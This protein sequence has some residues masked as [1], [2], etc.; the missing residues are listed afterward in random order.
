MGALSE[1]LSDEVG[2]VDARSSAVGQE[3]QRLAL[4]AVGASAPQARRALRALL[5]GTSYDD[6]ADDAVLAL[7]ELVTN[8]VLHGREPLTVLLDRDGARLR[9]EVSDGSPLGPSFSM[10]DP[11]AVTGRGLLL[12]SSCADRWGVE[13]TADGKRVWF[14]V[15]AAPAG[16][17]GKDVDVDALLASWG[18]ELE[19]PADEVVRVVL[20]DLD[21]GLMARS[22]AHVDA[23]LR[24]LALMADAGSCPPAARRLAD[25]VQVAAAEVEALRA[26]VKRQL[27]LAVAGEQCQLDVT[28]TITRVDADTVRDFAAVVDEADRLTRTGELLLEPADRRLSEVRQRYLRRIVAQLAS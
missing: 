25:R 10:L 24:E 13:P 20:T 27:T 26:E 23:L 2:D 4:P 5:H 22:E 6:R 19:D 15:D 17:P 16:A 9:V 18:E 12:V 21:T 3:V 14:E 8:A 1:R 28:L 11:T 7:S